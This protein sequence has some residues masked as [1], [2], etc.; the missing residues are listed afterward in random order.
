M[1]E[2]LK[3]L[4]CIGAGLAMTC[5]LTQARGELLAY[6][7][8]DYTEG[9]LS[10][11][12][13]GSGFSA[14]WP[15]AV[16]MTVVADSLSHPW[17]AAGSGNS[18]NTAA[19]SQSDNFR[20]FTTPMNMGNPQTIYVSWLLRRTGSTL[21][22]SGEFSGLILRQNAVDGL[23][24][25]EVAGWTVN[26]NGEFPRT[27]SIG[28]NVDGTTPYLDDETYF[29]VGKISVA[30]SPESDQIFMKIY[31]SSDR[32]DDSEPVAWTIIGGTED[33]SQILH[34]LRLHSGNAAGFSATFD[35]IRIGTTWSDVVAI[36][37]VHD[38]DA[39]ADGMVNLA[40]LQILGDNW[41]STTAN[42]GS[43]DFTGDGSVNLADLQI[44]GDN[45]GFGAAAD[46][47]FDQALASVSIP[48]PA[49]LTL[50]S[51]VSLTLLHRGMSH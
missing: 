7:G 37:P 23:S 29:V 14:A 19:T 20:D 30:A 17:I 5:M 43:A 47:S 12:N 21:G 46:I 31:S 33:N 4:A 39:N 49:T 9:A 11:Q 1:N 24:A 45:W 8:F 40:D 10:G 13:G 41:Q 38:G 26:S 25:A 50:L 27:Q 44:I 28:A 42:W 35:E 18:L 16:G 2:I 3:R 32:V 15:T 6:E 48:E 36:N 34:S 51:L 22:T